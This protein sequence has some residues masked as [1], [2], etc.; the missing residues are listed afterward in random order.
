MKTQ[1]GT[2]TT[3]DLSDNTITFEIEGDMTLCAG[4]YAIVPIDEYNNLKGN[5]PKSCSTTKVNLGDWDSTNAINQCPKCSSMHTQKSIKG[6]AW[7][8]IIGFRVFIT[9]YKLLLMSGWKEVKSDDM[10]ITNHSTSNTIEIKYFDSQSG[11]EVIYLDVEQLENIAKCIDN[12][13]HLD[14]NCL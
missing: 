7:F 1:F 2:A 12:I 13:R 6:F 5:S 3:G 4:Q 14:P 11:E 8:A 9:R 10:T